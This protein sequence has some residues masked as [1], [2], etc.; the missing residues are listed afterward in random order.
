MGAGLSKA[1]SVV[2]LNFKLFNVEIKDNVFIQLFIN[3]MGFV[4]EVLE[5]FQKNIY[6]IS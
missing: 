4:G 1:R 2:I 6:F 5:S 3:N